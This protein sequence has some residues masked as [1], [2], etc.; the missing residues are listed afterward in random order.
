MAEKGQGPSLLAEIRGEKTNDEYDELTAEVSQL[1]VALSG[2]EL[3]D[4]VIERVYRYAVEDYDRYVTQ[5]VNARDPDL[6]DG[7]HA[8]IRNELTGYLS[9]FI[10][11][12]HREF[13]V[14]AHARG[15]IYFGFGFRVD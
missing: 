10:T 4:A 13:I 5:G 3:V 9:Q 7:F 2:Y 14:R 12:S 1:I 11:D 6:I 8:L 15:A